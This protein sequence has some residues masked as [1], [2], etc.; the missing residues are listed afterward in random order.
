[1]EDYFDG[2]SDVEYYNSVY[3]DGDDDS[4][5][6]FQEPEDEID[7]S[8]SRGDGPSCKVL[9]M[10]MINWRVSGSLVKAFRF[11]L[12]LRKREKHLHSLFVSTGML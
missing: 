10:K 5:D 1:M 4:V 9:L 2:S 11:F 8:L 3:D 7:Y 12:V 6:D